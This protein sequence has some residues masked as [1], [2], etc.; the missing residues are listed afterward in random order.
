MKK[1]ILI[2]LLNICSLGFSQNNSSFE[3]KAFEFYQDSLLINENIQ[4][5]IFISKNLID[6]SFDENYVGFYFV[7][8]DCSKF[9][10]FDIQ[11]KVDWVFSNNYELDINK[12]NQNKFKV[13]NGKT[14]KY[15]MLRI[16]TPFYF[17]E[18]KETIYVNVLQKLS[19]F[20]ESYYTIAFDSS[21]NVK[22]WCKQEIIKTI[23]Y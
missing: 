2:I 13:K 21:Q 18:D 16:Y 23:V 15:P 11:N 14:R 9:K 17:L 5:K 7:P 19:K 12:I 1:I 8:G 3:E 22:F 20:K 10:K 4:S 6:L